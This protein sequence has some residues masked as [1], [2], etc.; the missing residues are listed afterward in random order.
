M[1]RSSCRAIGRIRFQRCLVTDTDRL[2]AIRNRAEKATP[3]PWAWQDFDSQFLESRTAIDRGFPVAVISASGMHTEGY[4]YVEP[5]DAAFIAAARDDIPWLLARI[6]QLEALDASKDRV[7]QR[8]IRE[9]REELRIAKGE[10]E[11]QPRERKDQ[12]D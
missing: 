7:I 2:T 3:G 9:H 1:E 6:A 10:P 11:R 12:H 4:V 8:L 5:A